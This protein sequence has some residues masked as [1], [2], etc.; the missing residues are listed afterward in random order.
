MTYLQTRLKSFRS[1]KK[2][3]NQTKEYNGKWYDSKFEANFA[4][5]LDWRK[6]AGEIKEVIP[7]FKISI[8]INDHHICNYFIDFKVINSDDSVTFYEVK[9][10]VTQLWNLKWKLTMALAEEIE[11]GAEWIIVKK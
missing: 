2:Y 5:E 6:K 11:P 7:Q 8:D 4:E 9:G 3:H 10:F 1:K